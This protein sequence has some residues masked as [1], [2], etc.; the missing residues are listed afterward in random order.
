MFIEGEVAVGFVVED[1]EV[2]EGGLDAELM[3]EACDGGEFDEGEVVFVVKELYVGDG[4]LGVFVG[5]GGA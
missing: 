1:G 5:V 2:V 4:F 3:G